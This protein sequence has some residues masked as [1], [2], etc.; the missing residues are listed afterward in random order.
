MVCSPNQQKMNVWFQAFGK[1]EGMYL[2]YKSD[3]K[4]EQEYNFFF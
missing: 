2:I 3:I 4:K 1:K